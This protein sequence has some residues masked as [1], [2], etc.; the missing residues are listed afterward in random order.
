MGR[1]CS[2]G[3]CEKGDLSDLLTQTGARLMDAAGMLRMEASEWRSR[4]NEPPNQFL[5][6]MPSRQLG[7]TA[8]ADKCERVAKIN[9]AAAA[10]FL[11]Q[12]RKAADAVG[13]PAHAST[14]RTV[15]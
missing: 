12:A 1:Y 9:E 6:H 10:V 14:Q 4:K 13:D 2:K 15:A 7:N 11:A 8:W 3:E 5:N